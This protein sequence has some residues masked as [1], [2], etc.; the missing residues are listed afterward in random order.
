MRNSSLYKEVKENITREN[1]IGTDNR[2][3]LGVSGGV[4]SMVMLEILALMKPAKEIIV[5]HIN[6]LVRGDEAYR[7][8]DF[9][10]GRAKDLGLDFLL[11]RED[12]NQMA[13]AKSISPEEAGREIRHKA[14]Q[15]AL[16]GKQGVI[17]LAHNKSDQVE[18]VLLNLFR[19]TGIAGLTAMDFKRG[20]LVRPLL[21]VSREDIEEFA[22]KYKLAFVEDRTN[23]ENIYRRN[24]IRNQL[25]PFIK[26]EYNPQ[27]EEAIW[28]MSRSL[29]EDEVLTRAYLADLIQSLV[30]KRVD[31]Q[32]VLSLNSFNRLDSAIQ[33]RLIRELVEDLMG[34][35]SGFTQAHLQE[36]L[37][38]AQGQEGSQMEINDLVF[39]KSYGQLILEKNQDL[40]DTS[41]VLEL[42]TGRQGTYELGPYK[43]QI[44]FS[45]EGSLGKNKVS[46]D[47]D[48]L[49]AKLYLRTRRPGDRMDVLGLGGSKKIKD[50]FI[51]D[52]V[53]RSLRDE[54][55]ILTDG[56]EI[57]W[58]C[59]G[60]RSPHYLLG[61]KS[62]NILIIEVI[63]S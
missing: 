49:P 7:D 41:Q 54:L 40:W 39:R 3:V 9:V 29:R 59:G 4:D 13:R 33:T 12:M 56:K 42:D 62:E 38:V 37:K 45:K 47:R 57:L 58:I 14:F 26:K 27:V 23:R 15:E 53:D 22:S 8:E 63:R 48:L 28:R 2:L 1:L 46:L 52:K 34:N 43:I 61:N 20:Q 44:S 25:L 55:P 32:I 51:D 31:N 16:A 6:H 17:G 21:N 18:T 11:H 36:Y 50:I 5:C 30:V 60:R 10:R 19:G 24:S 35:I